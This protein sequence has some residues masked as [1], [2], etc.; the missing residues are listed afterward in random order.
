MSRMQDA[1]PN[2]L[3]TAD[4]SMLGGTPCFAGMRVPVQA[5]FD[6]LKSGHGLTEF[7]TDYP[8]V[9]REHA[10]AVLDLANRSIA[11][12]VAAE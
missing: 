3:V 2:P 4:P 5:L 9:S 12:T 1:L 11:N 7:L 8:S 6:Y 10:L